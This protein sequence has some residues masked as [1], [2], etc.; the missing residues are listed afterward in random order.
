MKAGRGI[1]AP[2]TLLDA[3]DLV[4]LRSPGALEDAEPYGIHFFQAVRA[5]SLDSGVVDEDIRPTVMRKKS[6]SFGAVEPHDFARVLSHSL[7]NLSR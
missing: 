3:K 5:V 2:F 1:M 7:S 6:K 4:G